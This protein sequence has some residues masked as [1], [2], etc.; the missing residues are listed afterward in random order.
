MGKIFDLESPIMRFLGRL[1]DLM[2]LNILAIFMCLPVFTIGAVFTAMNS[3]MLK[4][5]RH[6]EG[7]VIK[8]YFKAFKENFVQATLTWLICLVV[9]GVLG[10]DI[11]LTTQSDLLP[12]GMLY[13][14]VVAAALILMVILYIF[15]LLSRF[16]NT[17]LGTIRNAVALAVGML[18]RSLA[19][20]AVWAVP[21]AI[22]M[23]IPNLYSVLVLFGL[24]APTYV[25]TMIY[26]P[27]FKKLEGT[28]AQQEPAS[29][30][31]FRVPE[32]GEA[33]TQVH[34]QEANSED[35]MA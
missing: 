19:M 18:P 3:I 15:P 8:P 6:E 25:C 29:D 16:N 13:A 7:Y 12:Q 28:A 2:V 10:A 22:F 30:M 31:D 24:S 27:V 26:S 17:I 20:I 35:S 11:Y 14:V 21:V 33:E 5:V 1:G 23:L 34:D 32:E 4:M 9:L